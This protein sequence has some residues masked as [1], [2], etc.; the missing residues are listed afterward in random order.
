MSKQTKHYQGY[1]RLLRAVAILQLFALLGSS[2]LAAF[3]PTLPQLFSDL[4]PLLGEVKT[5]QAAGTITGKVFH[6]FNNNGVNDGP[7]QETVSEVGVANVTVSAYDSAGVLQ[8]TATTDANG[9]YSLVA[10]G[11]GPYRIEFTD[12][13]PGY[14]PSSHGPNNGTSTQFVLDG[15]TA[16]VDFGVFNPTLSPLTL[17]ILYSSYFRD[18][19]TVG[20]NPYLLAPTTG[21]AVTPETTL[22]Q[23]SQT[24]S[25]GMI[26]YEPN[27]DRL[28]I[29]S[30]IRG[31]IA[32]GASGA[33]AIYEIQNVKTAPTAPSVLLNLAAG[34]P[35][36]NTVPPIDSAGDVPMV[37]RAGLGGID[38]NTAGT[39]LYVWNLFDRTLY[40][41]QLDPNDVLAAPTLQAT[42]TIT[43]ILSDAGTSCTDGLARPFAVKSH[44]DHLYAGV[45]CDASASTDATQAANL[46]GAVYTIDMSGGGTVAGSWSTA[47]EP[48][49]MAYPHGDSGSYDNSSF[50]R[51]RAI[52]QGIEPQP[53]ISDLEFTSDGYMILGV[54]DRKASTNA[55]YVY[56]S[57]DILRACPSAGQWVVE[58]NAGCPQ[59]SPPTG[60]TN[61][62]VVN[63]SV[64]NIV[65]EWFVGDGNSGTGNRHNEN[66][67]GGVGLWPG[68]DEVILTAFNA[69]DYVPNTGGVRTLSLSTGEYKRGFST[70]DFDDTPP[71]PGYG[72]GKQNLMGDIELLQDLSLLPIEIGN[73]VWQDL[74]GN[75]VQ[76]PGEPG[77]PGIT[78]SL[79]GPTNTVT[80]ITDPD[81]TY[82]FGNLRANTPYT[83]AID[84]AQP[85]LA[86]FDLTIA[87]AQAISGSPTSNDA[88]LDTRDS[89][90]T[91]AGNQAQILY[92]TGSAGQNNHGLDFGFA[93][94]EYDLAL[95]KTLAPGQPSLVLEGSTVNYVITVR[96]QGDVPS[97]AFTVT[98]QIPAGMAFV[99]ASGTNFNC[100]H[101]SGVVTCDYTPAAGGDLAPNTNA[102]I[103]LSLQVTDAS[104]APFRNWAEISADSGADVDSTPDTD[105]GNDDGPG[106]GTPPSAEDVDNHNDIFLDN[107]PNDEDDNDYE[108]VF[109]GT[110]PAGTSVLTVTKTISGVGSGP[111]DVTIEGPSGFITTTVDQGSPAVLEN[112]PAGTYTVTEMSPGPGWTTTYSPSQVIVL[113]EGI[114][115]PLTPPGDI[116]GNVFRDFNSNGVDDGVNEIGV[117]GV[118]VTAYDRDGV[119]RGTTTTDA[120]G[121]YT[122]TTTGNGP[123][124]IEFTDLP[125]GYEPSSH[126]TG[127][128]TSTQFVDA[129]ATD[130]NFGINYPADYCQDNPLLCT[131]VHVNNNPNSPVAPLQAMVRYEYDDSG[132]LPS[133]LAIAEKSEIGS[134]W[135]V[136]YSRQSDTIYTSAFLKRHAGLGPEGLGAIYQIAG[137]TDSIPGSPSLFI[138]LAAVPGV[139]VGTIADNATRGLTGAPGTPSQDP[140][141]FGEIGK[142]G[143]GDI[144]ISDDGSTLYVMNLN[145]QTLL[146]IPINNPAALSAYPVPTDFCPAADDTRPFATAYHRGKVYV[147]VVCDGTSTNSRA[148]LAAIVYEFDPVATTFTNILDFPLDY[149]KGQTTPT[150]VAGQDILTHWNPWSDNF[151]SS[152]ACYDN[153]HSY[154]Q[155]ILSDIE[156]DVDGSM[157]LGFLDR[158]GHQTGFL[159]YPPD[160]LVLENSSIN[161][162]ILRAYNNNG[163]FEL[164]SNGSAGPLVSSVGVGNGEG[165]GGG[166]FYDDF[167]AGLHHEISQ[168]ALAIHYGQGQVAY[169]A[170]DA[171]DLF[172]TG[173]VRYLNNFDGSEDHSYLLFPANS[174]SLFGKANGL[175][176][177]EILCDEAPI[178]I[179]NRVWRDLNGNGVQ[180]PGE[181]GIAGVEVSLQGPTTT[182]TTTTSADGLYYFGN[183]RPTTTYTVT[184]APAQPVLAD[185]ILTQPDAEAINGS[186]T[187]NDAILDTRDSDALTYN[188]LATIVYT[189]GSAGQNNHGL[190]FGFVLPAIGEVEITNIPPL[191][192]IGNYVW[193]DEDSDGDQDAGEPGIPNVRVVLK[194]E[195]GNVIAETRTDAQGGYLFPDLPFGDY[196]VDVDESTLP[197]GMTQTPVYPNPGSDL[198]NQDHSGDGYPVTIGGNNPP[199]NMTADFG[200]NYNPQPDVDNPGGPVPAALGD[201]IWIDS[202]GDGVQD[203]EEIGVENAQVTL[204]HD[205]DGDGIYDTPYTENGYNPV[206]VTDA[207]GYYLF[208]ELPPGAYTVRVTDSSGASHDILNP[209]VYDQTGDPDH[210]AAPE[211]TAVPGTAN[212]HYSTVPVV[213]GPGDVFLN[214]DFGY[215]PVPA[216][217]APLGSIGDTVWLDIDA[218]G[219]GPGLPPVDGGAAVTQGDDSGPADPLEYGIPGVTVALI[220]DG[221]GDGLWQP[222]DEPII[223]TTTTDTSGQYL[224]DDLPYGDY[225]VWVNDTD[226]VLHDLAQTYDADGLA[227]PNLS[228]RTIDALEPHPRDQ[229][230]GYT[231]NGQTPQLGAIG[232]TVW[233]DVDGSGGD[234]TTQ[235]DEPGIEGV[236]VNLLDDSGNIIR[237]TTTDEHGHYYFG[238]LPLNETYQV[239]VA[240]ENFLPGGVLEGMT[241]TYDPDSPLDSRGPLVTLTPA[242]PI[243]L[244]QDFSYVYVPPT[245]GDP[246]GRIGNLVWLDP[247]ANG[248]YEPHLGETPIGGVTVDLY[249][250]LN[251][252]GL[253]DAGEPLL[254]STVTSG[255]I[256]PAI[257]G[258]DGNYIF[259]G[260]PAG[261]YIVDVSDRNGVLAGYWQSDG[262]NDG[263]DNNSQIDPY[264]VSIPTGGEN[265]TAD[266][267]YYVDP[268]AV[269]NWVWF[270]TN[271]DGLQNDGETGIN[272]IR[273][274]L[275]ITYPGGVVS[276]IHT[277][278]GPDPL[279][280]NPGWY[281]FG[282]LLL[283]EDY[284]GDGTGPEP[285]FE[286]RVTDPPGLTRTPINQGADDT[287]DSDDH[288]GV[289]AQPIKGQTDTNRSNDANPIASYDFGYGPLGAI[290]NYVWVDEDSDGDQDAGEPGIPNV[291]VVLKDENGNVIAETRTDAQGG[292]LFPD[293]PFGDYYV[294]V[295][296]ST[297]PP[298]MTQTPVYPNPGS[299]LGNQD[300][301]GDGYPVTIG[302]NN[303]P[304]NMTADFG[305]NY[306]PQPDVDNPGGPVP[307]ALGDRIWIDSD[308]DGVQD[309]EEIGVENAQ[310]TLYHDPDGDGIYDT[311]YTENGYNPVDVT[312]ANGYYLFDELPPGAYTVRVTDSSGASHDILNPTVYDQTGDPDH[313][314]APEATAVPGTANDHY[315]TV[316]VVLGPGDVFLNVDFGYQPVPAGPAPLGSIGD[317]VWLDIDADG[318]GPGLPP[319]DGGA[320]VTQGDDSGPADP[321][322]YGI[323]GVTVALIR[324]GNGDGLWQP[325]DEPIIAT[326]TTDTSGQYLF[327][328]LPYGDYLVWVNDTDNVL[329]DLA[330]TYDADGLA[331]PNLSARTIDALEPHPRDQDFGYTPNGQTPQLGAIGDTVWFDVDGS[332]GDQTTQGDEPGIE[333]VIVNLLDDSGNIIRTTTTDE[334]GHY[335]FGGLPLNETYQVVVAPENFLP[336]GVLEGMTNTYDPD[337]PL[338]SRGPLVTLTPADP[339]NLDQDFSYVYVP[340][341]PGDPVGRI[342]NLVW[343]DPN[344]NGLYEPHLGETPI[345]GV[346]VDLYR[347]LNGNGLLDAGEPLLAST[348]TSGVIDPAIFGTDG[349]YIFTGLPAGDYIVDVSDRNGVLAGYWQS[350]G[351]NDGQDNN[352]QIDPYAVS[353]PTGGENLTADFGYYVDPAAVG[354]WVWFDTNGDG[355]QNDGETGINGIRVSLVITYPG[356]VVS[357][358][359]TTTGPDPLNGNPGWYSFGNLLLDEDYNG[360]GTGPEPQFEIRVT[361]PPGLTRTPINQGADDTLDSD[362]HDGVLAQPIKG[363]TDTNRSNDANPIAS[364]DFGY[365]RFDLAL[366]K[367][368][369]SFSQTP[370]V[371]GGSTVTF[372]I[373]VFN[374]GHLPADHIV[375]VDYVQPGF[376]Y[377]PALNPDWTQSDTLMPETTIVGPLAPGQSTTVQIVLGVAANTAGQTLENL[378]EIAEA[379][380]DNDPNTPPPTDVDSTPDRNND[381]NPVKDDV[382]DEDGK[383]NPGEDDEDDHDTSSVSI[384]IFDLALRKQLAPNHPQV[385]PGNNMNFVITI[386]NQGT[387]DAYRIQVVDTLP[388]GS[389]LVDPLWVNNGNGTASLQT[390]I[391]FLAAGGSVEIFI[392]LRVDDDYTGRSLVNYAEISE[393]DNDQDPTNT[394]PVDIDSSFDS[395]PTNDRGG[396]PGGPTDNVIDNTGN[397]EDDHDP[398]LVP[399]LEGV[400]PVTLVSFTSR[401]QDGHMLIEW[402]TSLELET[403]GFR[404][405]RSETRQFEDAVLITPEVILSQGMNGGSYQVIDTD[406]EPGKHYYYWLEEVG[407]IGD[408]KLLERTS[409]AGSNMLYLPLIRK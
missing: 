22:A 266:F 75:G 381:E 23:F 284:N 179:G 69:W 408:G 401:W 180:D 231:P 258:T 189:T 274:S 348:V 55:G 205:P 319:V 178:E 160:A 326:T 306:N 409:V 367:S 400:K 80:T 131:P 100:S 358:I 235:G 225:L 212:D 220:R 188:G 115:A 230:F 103:D 77:I 68:L 249:R 280:G 29:A 195:N 217:P 407:L 316:P 360:D 185:L 366:R 78:V 76:D 374:Q 146:S 363:Q 123:Y 5:A 56:T 183:L 163:T 321:L 172:W 176:D 323:P 228:A 271:G 42:K 196:Y 313:Y 73:R 244:D 379:D 74:N 102:T 18:G 200:Y 344:A 370:L 92:T 213:L 35:A 373:E 278:T 165:P 322:E 356:G 236:I 361:D 232:D 203:P 72:N 354:N 265:L 89:D 93:P 85:P 302:G 143:L 133:P 19:I 332:G 261:D 293:L 365:A 273:V 277:T 48:F 1:S 40:H 30:A 208:D 351:P 329:H 352:S 396:E 197:P 222:A 290:G 177:L 406:V 382:I 349:N 155:P 248:L 357:T 391:P 25:V 255:V 369:A 241:N 275:V 305:Y 190:D 139:D 270:D 337:S 113:G 198:G 167:A 134:A 108:D 13:P 164:E 117:A 109:V 44:G 129:G 286:I 14:E 184:I 130:V 17:K 237:T 259:T 341:T 371:P 298:G 318:N 21:D 9:D 86:G 36:A 209:T 119:Q 376:V 148:D 33:G 34:G 121:V 215:Q 206:D 60:W 90:A 31:L 152:V 141:P 16:D 51:W 186:P 372:A 403:H 207:N 136:A 99:S 338:D 362:D 301:S 81:G 187:S 392:T 166:E 98:D 239:V 53:I 214:V 340:P 343:L 38:T 144:D 193:V 11:T 292:Y 161:G 335:Y 393:A 398:A 125:A 233:F 388:D 12:L 281:S 126:G 61:R 132:I 243:N 288:D 254:A 43:D 88:I 267:G 312:D 359:H 135:G 250:D 111:F 170:M 87:N 226:N 240:P 324:D 107:P 355:L 192:A 386:V 116:T 159:N 221:N 122:L 309:P 299:D 262:P 67:T 251:G 191:G 39:G 291:R 149:T 384:G 71:I 229:D 49:S 234:Q 106:F 204:Y 378:A 8:G 145:Q 10:A 364:Y 105:T 368:V 294:D 4:Q 219:N 41:Y 58:G 295:D 315:S 45:V 333:G 394:P 282:N 124:R 59:N 285:Q 194:D 142:I 199:E 310:V 269:G 311:P 304:E 307:A 314:A 62:E 276:T 118:T 331:T 173:G 389:T 395:D 101:S 300:H 252:N 54:V 168:G 82:Y 169:T 260:L 37:S 201:R 296:E 347:D 154:P 79:Q 405:Y 52:N 375:V 308:G 27:S 336:G 350:D 110:V 112:I 353:I 377:D 402:V 3:P 83:V 174:P 297:L 256:D 339:I 57:G 263:Q 96:N 114:T 227:T 216:G 104:Q 330:Q 242:D 6:D 151:S 303:P 238:G 28:F 153:Q 120:S 345:G 97:G 397:D 182:L 137:A 283:D 279:N 317:T 156:F 157:I 138:D 399:I 158:W 94:P 346:T 289:L 380:N 320:A 127:N 327:D 91:Q 287:L 387:E 24:G 46:T 70:Y 66:S 181:P 404:L 210:Y 223:A 64:G 7:S 171:T 84:L 147:G 140:L 162:D 65:P 245:P 268:A 150:C 95:I 63:G 383:N 175:G 32:V 334:H 264:A 385:S 128:G 247:N 253:L 342:G 211:A 390:P 257:F 20:A 50:G 272:G 325:A 15:D 224:F 2:M 246:V 26:A 328:D 202:D 218:D 47:V